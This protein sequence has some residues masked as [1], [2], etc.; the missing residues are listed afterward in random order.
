ML[1][2]KERI[3]SY[4]WVLADITTMIVQLMEGTKSNKSVRWSEILHF[5]T[6]CQC[7]LRKFLGLF[8]CYSW[9]WVIQFCS[10]AKF[11]KRRPNSLDQTSIGGGD[12]WNSLDPVLNVWIQFS[13]YFEEIYGMFLCYGWAW[14]PKFSSR[15]KFGKSRPNLL[16][17]TCIGVGIVGKVWIQFWTFE[18][19]RRIDIMLW[20][21]SIH[22]QI[23]RSTKCITVH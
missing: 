22:F 23:E 3:F 10:G 6:P 5:S 12:I 18:V 13:M 7:V 8:L 14:V 20:I 21:T 15:A 1:Q 16:D 19:E 4:S 11:G 2:S 9:V 17:Y